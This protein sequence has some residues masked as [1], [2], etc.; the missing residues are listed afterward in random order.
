VWRAGWPVG[1]GEVAQERLIE[2]DRLV[3]PGVVVEAAELLA[4]RLVLERLVEALD[5]VL[6]YQYPTPECF[7]L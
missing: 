4:G 3:R 1:L 5:A 2:R 6:G 7:Y